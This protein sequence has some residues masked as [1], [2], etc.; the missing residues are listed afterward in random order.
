MKLQ[1]VQLEPYD[2]TT[3]IKD[4]LSSVKADRVLLVWPKRK[5][6]RLLQRKLDLV[7]IQREAERRKARLALVTADPDVIDYA[8]ELNITVFNSV[9]QGQQPGVWKQPLNKVF[10]ERAD[11][12]EGTP[13]PFE[14]RLIASR[15]RKLTPQ[16]RRNR[17]ILRFGAILLLLVTLVSTAVVVLPG[18]EVVIHPAQSQIDDVALIT[19]DPQASAIDYDQG[20]IPALVQV[21]DVETS[22][23]IP[24]TGVTDVAN[25]LASGTVIFTNQTNDEITIPAGTVVFSTGRDPARFRTINDVIVPAGVGSTANT[26]IQAL[27]DTS[28]TKGNIEPNLIINIEG[29]LNDV[30]GVRNPDFTRGGSVRPQGIVT[31]ADYNN[32]L[33]LARDK[34]RQVALTQFSARLTSG[35]IVVPES[36][37]IAPGA[38]EETTYSAFIG[39]PVETLT[40]TLRTR[41][42]ALVIDQQF[43]RDAAF[44]SLSRQVRLQQTRILDLNSVTYQLTA[45]RPPDANGRVLL[46]M[47]VSGRIYT[48]IDAE[49]ARQRISGSSI[50]AAIDALN[51]DWVLDPLRP[52]EIR[53]FPGIFGRLPFL[54][55]RI[56]IVIR[57]ST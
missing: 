38:T 43:A 49:R 19:A 2:D 47:A 42:R 8:R 28:G 15:L 7:L 40:L 21:I 33:P 32:L 36:I 37:Q 50:S 1:I 10:V 3:S 29:P 34:I 23:S 9:R 20:I 5:S 12:P 46:T 17:L 39:D 41:V 35:Q 55:T 54:T 14:L 16:E 27:E 51:R 18:A 56:T 57:T 24:T 11:R 53:V 52:P 13:D 26:N 4:R 6:A 45:V 44:A 22:A 48:Q 31:Q 25:S 30:L